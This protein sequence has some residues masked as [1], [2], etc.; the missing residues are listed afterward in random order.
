MRIHDEVSL[1]RDV[2]PA[3]GLWTMNLLVTLKILIVRPPMGPFFFFLHYL[4]HR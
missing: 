1:Q 2:F 3:D 4:E